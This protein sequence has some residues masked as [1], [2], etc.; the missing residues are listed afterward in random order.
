MDYME[1]HSQ[2]RPA[3]S[4]ATRVKTQLGKDCPL[5]NHCVQICCSERQ[6]LSSMITE[7][8]FPGGKLTG[9]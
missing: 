5:C 7:G 1:I 4:R 2:Q 8:S 9:R 3:L 6:I